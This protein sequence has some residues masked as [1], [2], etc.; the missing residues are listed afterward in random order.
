[1][2][3]N[4]D[5]QKKIYRRRS[6]GVTSEV[7]CRGCGYSEDFRF[8]LG[9]FHSSLAR[10]LGEFPYWER[11]ELEELLEDK[12]VSDYQFSFQLTQCQECLCLSSRPTIKFL[13]EDG[14][15]SHN[16]PRCTK[17]RSENVRILSLDWLEMARCPF[18][19]EKSLEKGMAGTWD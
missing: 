11:K 19:R 2:E 3:Y 18:C 15:H 5:N 6:Y 8:G 4:K 12:E 1:M 10:C 17:C 13:F 16:H 9:M 14:S 7:R